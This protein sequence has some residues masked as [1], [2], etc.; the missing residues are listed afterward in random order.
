MFSTNP[1]LTRLALR[2]RRTW[3]EMDYAQR[4]LFEIQTGLRVTG[5]RPPRR[6]RTI[7]ELERLYELSGEPAGHTS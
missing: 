2:V 5:P 7:E 4:R 3:G 6:A 1:S